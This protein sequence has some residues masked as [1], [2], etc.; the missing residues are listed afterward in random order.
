MIQLLRKPHES[1]ISSDLLEISKEIKDLKFFKQ[2]NIHGKDLFE[3]CEYMTYLYFE[4]GDSLVDYGECHDQMYIVIDGQVDIVV[5]FENEVS[6]NLQD[7]ELPEIAQD[8]G[9]C[10]NSLIKKV[11]DFKIKSG[12]NVDQ[13][14]LKEMQKIEDDLATKMTTMFQDF[15][16]KKDHC[17]AHEEKPLE[18][19]YSGSKEINDYK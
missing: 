8:L 3:V 2:Q 7:K 15:N 11:T 4:K 13:K 1:R 6:K 10:G 16:K 12:L 17:C 14:L 19:D 9:I 18:R 5:D